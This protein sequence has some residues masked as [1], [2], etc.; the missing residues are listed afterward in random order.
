MVLRVISVNRLVAAVLVVLCIFA[1]LP[2]LAQWGSGPY[3]MHRFHERHVQVWRGGNWYHGGYQGRFGWYW[4]VGGV[5]YP[6]PSPIYP[7]PD[8]Y[9]P[10]VVVGAPPVVSISSPKPA[11]LASQPLPSVW[12]FCEA[13]Q[14][15]YPYVA[16][17]PA[18]WKSVP[19]IPPKQ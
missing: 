9:I 18:G 16:E 3:P 19:A 17:C 8:P 14:G 10:G 2:V 1:S 6:Y 7:Y 4:V 5:Y 12:Y 13:S 11:V 15:Y